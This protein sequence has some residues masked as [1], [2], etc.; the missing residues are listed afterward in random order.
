MSP[1]RNSRHGGNRGRPGFKFRHLILP[2]LAFVATI[3]VLRWAYGASSLFD[4]SSANIQ[5]LVRVIEFAIVIGTIIF[6][7]KE[8]ID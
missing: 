6:Y 3:D 4:G 7:R 5:L 2:T 8:L 1:Y